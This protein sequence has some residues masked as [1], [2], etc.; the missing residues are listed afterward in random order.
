MVQFGDS[1]VAIV[2]D[3]EP[4]PEFDVKVSDD[5]KTISCWI[6]SEEGKVS[7][8]DTGLLLPDVDLFRRFSCGTAVRTERSQRP[9]TFTWTAN[10]LGVRCSGPT[11][12]RKPL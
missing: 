6:P 8:I 2:V 5:A 4:L 11:P 12:T 9:P 10:G 7:F 3:G 1:S